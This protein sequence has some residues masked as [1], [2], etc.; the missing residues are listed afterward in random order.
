MMAMHVAESRPGRRQLSL[1][2]TSIIW[3][4]VIVKEF[5]C[6]VPESLAWSGG[7]SWRVCLVL[8]LAV[9]VVFFAL[10]RSLQDSIF[11]CSYGRVSH[12]EKI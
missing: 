11:N 9:E 1:G 7:S 2:N 10:A 5:A 6:K 4:L 12:G 8:G 3:Q